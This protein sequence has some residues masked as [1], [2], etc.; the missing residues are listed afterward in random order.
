[1]APNISI[2][3][4][5]PIEN[6][7]WE[8]GL[9]TKI[10]LTELNQ[11]LKTGKLTNLE[12]RNLHQLDTKNVFLLSHKICYP[13]SPYIYSTKTTEILKLKFLSKKE[14]KLL[15]VSSCKEPSGTDTY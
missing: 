15:D 1:M 11:K 10:E 4:T 8:L 12:E 3:L 9:L 7:F 14:H 2:H 5:L 13:C 6:T